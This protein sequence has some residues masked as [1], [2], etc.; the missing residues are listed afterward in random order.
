MSV[1]RIGFRGQYL[2][3]S[4][5][6]GETKDVTI[7]LE[8][9]AYELPEIEVTARSAKPIEYAWTHKYDDF[10]RRRWVGLGRYITRAEIEFRKPYR[11]ANLLAG[12]SCIKVAFRH[13]GASGT[14]V[15]FTCLP[16]RG[17]AV[18]VWIDGWKQRF[19]QFEA[20]SGASAE[21]TLG[22]YLDRVLPS[23]IEAMEI[24]RGPAEMPAEFLDDSCAAIAIWTR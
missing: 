11:T 7:V 16:S 15:K 19:A 6:A 24:Y 12:I 3:A 17:C 4:L 10:F 22:T 1:R 20:P 5:Q 23:Q 8:R 2:S 21:A 9:G 18:S 14:D 13:L